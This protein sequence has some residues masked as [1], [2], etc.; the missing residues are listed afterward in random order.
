MTARER[1][2]ERD[3]QDRER[4]GI[5]WWFAVQSATYG[6]PS[7]VAPVAVQWLSQEEYLR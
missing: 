1:G 2:R 3:C 7:L 4:D 5:W 6:L